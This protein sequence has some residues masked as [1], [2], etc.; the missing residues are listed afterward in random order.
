[1][2]AEILL[3][4]DLQQKSKTKFSQVDQCNRYDTSNP[5]MTDKSQLLI[6]HFNIHEKFQI[7]TDTSFKDQLQR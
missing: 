1:M 7:K 3:T 2:H 6:V 4:T 5:Y